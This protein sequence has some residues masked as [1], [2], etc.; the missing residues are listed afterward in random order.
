MGSIIVTGVFGPAV[1]FAANIYEY[2]GK[3]E[4]LRKGTS[5]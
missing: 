1:Y 2:N 5:E 4:A 3:N